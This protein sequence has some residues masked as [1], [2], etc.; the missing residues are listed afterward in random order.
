MQQF[1]QPA[2]AP[3]QMRAVSRMQLAEKGGGERLFSQGIV[4]PTDKKKSR[5]VRLGAEL[6]VLRLN[7]I[8]TWRRRKLQ[9]VAAL[10][11]SVTFWTRHALALLRL[12]K[13]TLQKYADKGTVCSCRW[14]RKELLRLLS[15]LSQVRLLPLLFW[16]RIA[17]WQSTIT[18]TLFACSSAFFYFDD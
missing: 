14:R 17:Q 15:G 4:V 5:I 2:A 3:R 6:T 1:G 9:P 8:V 12:L 16:R 13:K 7:K 18:I 10:S 11:Y